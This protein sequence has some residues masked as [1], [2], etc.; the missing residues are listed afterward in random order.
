MV[1]VRLVIVV[2]QVRYIQNMDHLC[3]IRAHFLLWIIKGARHDILADHE[4][5]AVHP[6]FEGRVPEYHLEDEHA[7]GPAVHRLVVPAR[8]D[9][10]GREVVGRAAQSKCFAFFDYFG[11]PKVN[12]F[13]VTLAV[14]QNIFWLHISLKRTTI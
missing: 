10:L 5:V 9:D 1:H 6:I 2:Q 11:K 4:V 12:N 7:H 8:E 13:W 14:N 3:V